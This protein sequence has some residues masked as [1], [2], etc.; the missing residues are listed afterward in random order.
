MKKLLLALVLAL[1]SSASFADNLDGKWTG[2]IDAGQGPIEISYV[3]KAIG[4]TLTGTTTGPDG[5]VIMIKNGKIN[6][7]KI[8]FDLSLDM[9]GQAM[10][11]SYTGVVAGNEIKL[12]SEF[13]GMPFDF[14][15]K[16]A[17]P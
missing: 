6:G 8:A 1:A 16:K 4:A 10:T 5:A 11:F 2:S 7:D 13:M 15:V 17:A 3:F 9:Q 14:S 12:H